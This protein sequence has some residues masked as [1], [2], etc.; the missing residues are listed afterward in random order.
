RHTRATIKIIL[1]S[2]ESRRIY[3]FLCL[4]LAFMFVQMA[5]GVWTNSLGLI[6]DSIHMFFDCLALGMGLFASVMATWPSN[7]VYT[8][9]YS[10]VETLSGFANG[11]F[12]CLISIFIVFEAIQR[13]V[14]PPEMNTGQLLTVSAVGLAT[15][16]SHSHAHEHANG[17]SHDED[18]DGEGDG[19]D[20]DGDGAH[21]GHSHNM[22]GVFL[23]VLADT[24]GSVGVIISTL[25]INRYGWNGFDPLASIFIAVMIFAS[26]VPLVQE[27]GR[28]LVLD[29]GPEREAEL[30]KALVEVSRLQGVSSFTKP[31]FWLLDPLTMVGSI[32]IQL[33]PAS[34]PYDSHGAPSRHYAD[35]AKT[36]A[37]VRRTLKRHVAGLEYLTIQMEPTGG[38]TSTAA[39]AG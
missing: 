25:L 14:D 10:R 32:C 37:R 12:L 27:S 33:A 26:V 11:V 2:P 1:A 3:F 34:S 30:R 36:K 16:A 24:L 15:P 39:H 4:N 8:Y 35:F 29:M 22:K 9:G 6:S 19:A 7:N 28:I 23:H 18:S 17:H 20:C 5:Y 31:R 21:G 13:L 38:W